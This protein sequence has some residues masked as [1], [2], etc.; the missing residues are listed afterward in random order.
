MASED[1]GASTVTSPGVISAG[2][3]SKCDIPNEEL[4]KP[5][6]DSVDDFRKEIERLKSRLEEERRKLNDVT[7]K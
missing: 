3:H 2:I 6:V 5:T 4:P 7:C 1:G